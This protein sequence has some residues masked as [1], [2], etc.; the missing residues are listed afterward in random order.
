MSTFFRL[1]SL[2]AARVLFVGSLLLALYVGL[3]WALS[4][5]DRPDAASIARAEALADAS[6]S[7]LAAQEGSG[8]P[9]EADAAAGPTA[10][11]TDVV[12]TVDPQELI[13]AALPPG[14]TTVQLLDAGGGTAA[15]DAAA[16]ALEQLGYQIVSR[17]S[18]S[19]KVDATTV[20]YTA[21]NE[22]E[23]EALR[24]RDP[25]FQSVEA[26]RGLN[27]GVNVH[28]LVGNF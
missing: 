6:E 11:P 15:V 12:A 3:N 28:V 13:A 25:R 27:E 20:Y 26:N 8:D 22:A 16:S 9:T 23:A 4:I 21:D 18:S 17:A 7:E 14:E 5:E 2:N 1:I 24:A 19:R 10:A